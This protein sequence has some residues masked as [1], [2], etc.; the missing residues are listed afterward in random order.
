[1][2]VKLSE[3]YGLGYREDER[4]SAVY[5]DRPT[6]EPGF[7]AHTADRIGSKCGDTVTF[8]RLGRK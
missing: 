7:G 4:V 2:A 6:R 1:V 5:D 8:I 3:Q